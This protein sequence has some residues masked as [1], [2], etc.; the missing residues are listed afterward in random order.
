MTKAVCRLASALKALITACSEW[1]S[2]LEV[3][4]SNTRIGASLST[5]RAIDTR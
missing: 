4:S 1:L 3:A 5:A 2:R